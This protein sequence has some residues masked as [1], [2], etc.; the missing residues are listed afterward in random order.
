MGTAC[1]PQAEL[2]EVWASVIHRRGWEAA[3]F[4]G[5]SEEL[6]E[7]L[8]VLVEHTVLYK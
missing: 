1:C 4:V 2:S 7:K 6:Y 3:F 5:G 8:L